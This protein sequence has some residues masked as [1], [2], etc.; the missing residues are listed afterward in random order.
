MTPKFIGARRA[1]LLAAAF[2][3]HAGSARAQFNNVP[4]PAVYAIRNATVVNADGTRMAGVNVVVRGSVI[5]AIAANAAIPADAQ[6]LTGDSLYVYPGLVDALGAV[7]YNFP[8]DTTD[9]TR[10][11]S[12]DPPR[13]IQGFMPS[14][15]VAGFLQPGTTELADLRKK[16]VVAVAVHPTDMIM[17]GQGALL[18]LRTTDDPQRLVISPSLGTVMSTRGA[19]GVYPATGMAL[20]P[21]YRQTFFDAQRMAVIAQ[22][23]VTDPRGVVPPAYDADYDVIQQALAGKTQVW[24]QANSLEEIET[25][26]KLADEFHF[27]PVIT[28]G[29][30][31]WRLA[32][33]L[34][35]RD[36]AVLVSMDFPKP[37]QWKPEG[38]KKDS[39]AAK[40]DSAKADTVKGPPT[41]G[42]LREKKSL[43]DMYA[44]AGRL[45]KAG[46]RFA[47]TSGYG[48]ADLREGARKAIEFGLS[49]TDAL[50]ALTRTPAQIVGAAAL[51]RVEAGLPATF[52]VTSKPLFDKNGKVAYTFVEGVMEKGADITS[53]PANTGRGGAR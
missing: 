15:R 10:V 34:K 27:K 43:E 19:R 3:A 35:K 44:N 39:A 40:P 7:K 50:R 23:A 52:V 13:S 26:F 53:K 14:R 20:T 29:S 18:M 33:E 11:R 48:K 45:A 46:V 25:V 9:R 6:V 32:P 2:L 5:E 31:A 37:T 30:E 51:G 4:A 17:P 36:M 49:E 16:G 41:P 22:A 47:L 42:A 12:W 8:R 24:F 21:F 1:V 28:G 38:E